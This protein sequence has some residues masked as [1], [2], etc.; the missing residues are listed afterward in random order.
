MSSYRRT[1]RKKA[2]CAQKKP[3]EV[4]KFYS[5]EECEDPRL[6]QLISENYCR[7]MWPNLQ[8]G[9]YDVLE[10]VARMTDE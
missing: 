6:K 5:L 2:K 3:K 1:S 7:N 8:K 4:K 10:V 9:G